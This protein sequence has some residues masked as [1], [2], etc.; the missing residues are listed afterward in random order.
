MV[1]IP[2]FLVFVVCMVGC[3][4]HA[5]ALGKT[6]GVENTIQYL[7]DK[8]IVEFEGFDDE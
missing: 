5:H 7:H 2:S 3:A 6:T 1:E 8:G 4:L